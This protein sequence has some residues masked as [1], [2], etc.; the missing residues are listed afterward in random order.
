MTLEE[1]QNILAANIA[2]NNGTLRLAPQTVSSPEITDLFNK[3]LLNEELVIDDA[4]VSL[5]ADNVIVTGKGNS[6]VFFD[7][8]INSLGFTVTDGVPSIFVKATAIIKDEDGWSFGRSFP[9]LKYSSWAGYYDPGDPKKWIQYVF[10]ESAEFSLSATELKFSGILKF[11]GRIAP[12]SVLFN[13][14]DKATVSGAITLNKGTDG[15]VADADTVV[16][17]MHLAAAIGSI[18]LPLGSFPPF[19]LTFSMYATAYIV[20]DGKDKGMPVSTLQM[21]IESSLHVNDKD[22]GA[23]IVVGAQA[24]SLTMQ[25][26]IPKDEGLGMSDLIALA[27]NENLLAIM[28]SNIPVINDFVLK[29]WQLTFNTTQKTLSLV[30]MEVCTLPDFTWTLIP[31]YLAICSIDIFMVM[32][33]LSGK[34]SPSL[35]IEGNLVIGRGEG[36]V[37]FIVSASFPSYVF[38]GSLDPETPVDLVGVVRSLLGETIANSLPKTLQLGILDISIDP[39][40]TTYSLAAALTTDLEIN[41]LLTTIVVRSVSFDINFVAGS[42]SGSITGEFQVGTDKDSPYLYVSAAYSN[43]EDEEGW[44]FTGGLK[45]GSEIKLGE[46]IKTYLPEDYDGFDP[47]DIT[48]TSFDATFT[49]AASSEGGESAKNTYSFQLGALWKLDLGLTAPMTITALTEIAY[50][51]VEAGSPYTGFIQGILSLGNIE[52]G[53]RVNLNNENNDYTFFFAGFEAKLTHKDKDSI[54]TFQYKD[55]TTLGQMIEMLVSAA[56]GESITLPSPWNVMNNIQMKNFEF[57]FNITQ[58]QIGLTYKAGINLGFIDIEKITLYYTYSDTEASTVKI[59]IT[60]GTFLGGTVPLPK[61]WNVLEPESAPAVPGKGDELFRLDFL[62][63]GQHVS[64]KNGGKTP[65]SV[66]AAV[67]LLK[68]GFESD[69]KD[70]TNPIADTTLEFNSA[71]SWLIGTQFK[72]VD[73]FAIGIVFFDPDLYGLSLT[74][75]GPKAKIFQG[76]KFEILYKKVSDT[77]GVYQV[78]LKLPDAIRQMEFGAVS[79]T[80]PSIKVYIYT[81]GDF[82]VDLG[83]PVNDDYSESFG[84]QLLP[85]VGSGGFYF[86]VL[87][88]ETADTVPVISNGNFSPVIVFGV[89][90]RVG[91]GK[92]IDK[93]V[94]KAGISIVIQGL[95]EGTYA[96]FN[97]YKGSGNDAAYYYILGK[98]AIVG[99]VYGSIDFLIVSAEVDLKVFVSARV[100]FESYEPILL[101]LSAGVSVSVSVKINLGFF[102]IRINMSYSTSVDESFTI[103]QSQPTPWIKSGL[104]A[105]HFRPVKFRALDGGETFTEVP[106]M[107]WQPVIPAAKVPLEIMYIPQFTAATDVDSS[108]QKAQAVAMLYLESA[109]DQQVTKQQLLRNGVVT[110]EDY[111]FTTF[112]K[113]VFLWVLGAYFNKTKEGIAV[114]TILQTEIT[115]EI[116]SNVLSYFSQPGLVEPFKIADVLTFMENYLDATVVIP[117]RNAQAPDRSVSVLPILPNLIFETPAGEV[118]FNNEKAQYTYDK[119]QLGLIHQY[120]RE[121]SLRNRTKDANASFTAAEE[122]KQSLATFM[123]VD[124]IA[125]LAKESAQ[126]GI[127]RLA[128]LTL[129]V[130]EGDSYDDIVNKYPN[131]G[132]SAIELAHANRTRK[133]KTR[134]A[135]AI[136]Q[137]QYTIKHNDTLQSVSNRFGVEH[138]HIL[139]AN[140][141]SRR[142]NTGTANTGEA[143]FSHQ[144]FGLS[145]DNEL[146][147]GARIVIPNVTHVTSA[148]GHESMLSVANTYGIPVLDLIAE[149]TGVAGVLPAG[150]HISVPFV[151]A[152]TVAKL[153]EAMDSNHDFEHLSGLSANIMLQGLRVPLPA[154]NSAIGKPEAMYKVS[155]QE[156]DASVL[157]AG[158]DLTIKLAEPLSWLGLGEPGGIK[159]PFTLLPDD[160]TALQGLQKAEL[161]PV[162]TELTAAGLYQVQARKFTLPA[163]ITWQAPVAIQLANGDNLLGDTVD[164]SIWQFKNSLEALLAGYA[165]LAPKVRLLKQVQETTTKTGLPQPLNN[166]S[167]STKIDLRLRQVRAAADPTAAMANT[168]EL[169]GIDAATM[170]LLQNLITYYALNPGTNIIRDINILY[171]KEPARDGQTAPPNGLRSDSIANT[172]MY[173]LQTNLSTLSNPPQFRAAANQT[174]AEGTQANLLGMTQLDFV[175]YMWESAVVGTG[176]YYL[177]YQVTDSKAGLPDYLFS[178]DADAVISVVITYQFID[179]VL[180]NFMNSVVIREAVDIQNEILY[181]ETVSQQLTGITAEDDDTLQSIAKRYNTSVSDIARQNSGLR[182]YPGVGLSIPGTGLLT[183]HVTTVAESL[184][185]IALR[186]DVDVVTLAHAN[187]H[188][189]LFLEEPLTFNSSIQVKVATVPPGNIGFT[190]RRK[191]AVTDDA[192]GNLL[193][194]YNLLGYS[195]APNKDFVAS[196][197]GLPVA[198]GNTDPVPPTG[199]D[200][201]PRP[202]A[203]TDDDLQYSRIVPVYP[204]VKEPEISQLLDGAPP[205]KENPYRAI[206]KKVEI[207][208]VW[209]DI[210]GNLTAFKNTGEPATVP[211]SLPPVTVGYTD[212]VIGLSLFPSVSASYLIEKP[213][214]GTPGLH[215]TLAFNPTNYLPVKEITEDAWTKRA[216]AD[217]ES[218]K[219]IYYQLIQTDMTVSISNS[220]EGDTAIRAV[221]DSA[222]QVLIAMV[223]NIYGYLNQILVPNSN[224][225]SFYTVKTGD[226]LEKIATAHQT[227]AGNIRKLNPAIAADG[228]LT[229]GQVII[230]SAVVVPADEII[231][232]PVNDNNSSSLFALT[233]KFTLSRSI[234]LI[235]VNFK[236]EPSVLF[237]TSVLGPNLKNNAATA[238]QDA[239]TIQD[240]ARALQNAFPQL[241]VASGMPQTGD[242]G[243]VEIWI[244]RFDDSSTGITFSV[245]NAGTPYYFA[246]LPLSTH[247]LSREAVKIYPYTPGSAIYNATPYDAAFNGIDIERM[248]EN[249]L[250]AI[251]VFL[252]A[253]FAVPAW[254]VENT[255][256]REMPYELI[257]YPYQS[258]IASKQALADGIVTHLSTVLEDGNTPADGNIADARERLRQQLLISLGSAYTIDT[259]LQFNVDVK[260]QYTNPAAA[261]PRLFGKVTGPAKSTDQ[262]A[263]AFSTTRFSLENSESDNSYLTMLFNTKKDSTQTEKSSYFPI[264]LQYEIN[265]LEHDIKNVKGID[266]YQASSWLTF[267]LPFGNTATGLGDLKIPIPLRAY[268]T[269]PSLTAQSFKSFEKAD[270]LRLM[271]AADEDTLQEAKEWDY[272]Y[273]YDYLPAQQ[274]TINTSITVNVP[275]KK[276]A[277]WL[278]NDADAPDL[279]AAL[280]QFSFAYPA[281]QQDFNQ[282]LAGTLSPDGF[283]TAMQSFAWL[284][285]RV[286]SAWGGWSENKWMYKDP[287]G[288]E[289]SYEYEITDGEIIIPGKGDK[290]VTKDVKALLVTVAPLHGSQYPLPDVSIANYTPEIIDD[291]GGDNSLKKSFVY[292]TMVGGVKKYLSPEAGRDIT[293]RVIS[294]AR[295]NIIKQENIWSGLSVTRNKI[296]VPGVKT[297]DAFVYT[298]PVIRF[299]SVLTPLLDPAI[300]INIANYTK[301]T[302]KQ[303]LQLYISNFLKAL[304]AEI[305]SEITTRQLKIGTSYSYSLHDSDTGLRTEIPISITTP[306]T[307]NIPADW[308]I[309]QCPVSP[310]GITPDSPFVC[311][312]TALIEKWFG[313]H[314]PVTGYAKFM[315]DISLFSGLSNTQL[316]VLRLR[317]IYIDEDNIKWN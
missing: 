58:K 174:P 167:W 139:N 7:T 160:Y 240:F 113:G 223:L 153:M 311:Q 179:N 128:T 41:V 310:G 228:A 25:A 243:P 38:M 28:P 296:L 225:F 91:I 198:P 232:T 124:Y 132:I 273:T 203:I 97:L 191:N 238:A 67:D 135:L 245:K 32:G 19:N 297:N 142:E 241:K 37:N 2:A 101:S 188:L 110:E 126:K 35:T 43:E 119:V 206:G 275:A 26:I 229:V 283:Y 81:N 257:P 315:F 222:K 193:E 56:T 265:S 33:Y 258:V 122:E 16:P 189:P 144:I 294:Y 287:A 17:E 116:L 106:A 108:V 261:A 197:P 227:T 99:H 70:K 107:N 220:L 161:L 27:N 165:A 75:D 131:F 247:L 53:A 230:V 171:A 218:Y 205:E 105:A 250:T 149:N 269:S 9:V 303:P 6:L 216:I 104:Y 270:G 300:E 202:T 204:F 66:S 293:Q 23:S 314:Q 4:K 244:A 121:L 73:T 87:S 1:I 62:G 274:D 146:I 276:P 21:L 95:L 237:S 267:I 46:I 102:S 114:D 98:L 263:Y 159:L 190:M 93:G 133:L 278:F 168:Y 147:P 251:D 52:V 290:E 224:P 31:G 201:A 299:I 117:P 109:I 246:L 156:I 34:L 49:R 60:E 13:G 103:G 298:T 77:V 45:E 231:T 120:F 292:Y 134:V 262:M 169:H 236:D 55:D 235:D 316:P 183:D 88:A 305:A 272:S 172:E 213:E 301:E 151:E 39:K 208:M 112:A 186:Y 306:Y 30:T 84:L 214:A 69:K 61:A 254:L 54:I 141:F 138:Q 125:L 42:P 170:A 92:E 143:L 50:A 288:S 317:N 11:T 96:Q 199:A 249:C 78:F 295:F 80:L 127:D 260:S 239:V 48:I 163:N 185:T 76:L 312:I 51:P 196:Q 221:E 89:G 259:V 177:Y 5:N 86:G 277:N 118:F 212:P 184:E 192:A 175:T 211:V 36:A 180:Q 215:I 79:V 18:S 130:D 195:I 123:L 291:K 59:A 219:Q 40:N 24:G 266:G 226:T 136:K 307:F 10:F 154:K 281:I 3:Y 152:L 210:F 289:N 82:K 137:V 248:A 162:L 268:P 176:G 129:A 164:P 83:F 308:D 145:R 313:L 65:D 74:V 15:F 155:G 44:V 20:T 148:K 14:E 68:A 271:V 187:K 217:N 12:L 304:F 140:T 309:T 209:Q 200:F 284:V 285:G 150:N 264:N 94:F 181:I 64:L 256:A 90:L 252:Q 194:L 85:F 72:I 182:F 253:G 115:A 255:I 207:D 29:D 173:L 282:Y 71:S 100:V 57:S 279:F 111:P 166:Y 178:G 234:N 47:V 286:A 280:L 157:V 63:L 233:T 8:E 302:G 22:L 158:D 242:D